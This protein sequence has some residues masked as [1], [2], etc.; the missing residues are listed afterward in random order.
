MS[1][2][3]I[4]IFQLGGDVTDDSQDP[5][6]PEY[7]QLVEQF[8]ALKDM[9]AIPGGYPDAPSFAKFKQQKAR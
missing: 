1:I 5:L 3:K 6:Y 7:L 9:P 4:N 8:E 2:D